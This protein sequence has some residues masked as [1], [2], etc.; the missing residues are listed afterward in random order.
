MSDQD[1]RTIVITGSGGGIGRALSIAAADVGMQVFGLDV[2]EDNGPETTR[3]VIERGGRATFF[4][5]DIQN[6]AALEAT[7]AAIE[8]QAGPVDILINNA[9]VGSHTAP[10][11]IT[12]EEWSKVI[13][14]TL[15][16]S[17]FAAQQA[18]R[19]M[20]RAGRAGAIVNIASIAGLSSLGRGSFAYGIAKAGVVSLTRE[21]A[22]E[23]ADY[24]IRVNGV[25]PSQVDTSSFRRLIDDPDVAGGN[26]FERALSG[27][28][29]GR[30][31]TT[32]DI[33]SVVMFLASEQAAFVSGVTVPVDG[34]SMAL[35]PGGSLRRLSSRKLP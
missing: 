18:G 22:V 10:E 8:D 35:H 17:V 14:V 6:V 1:N 23:W 4:P 11:D 13:G 9:A 26:I 28:P 2:E 15:G 12:F 3:I 21:L 24:G 34:G 16:G 5:C 25:A 19:S 31:A 33:V 30:L 32:E 7:F 20:I 27:I 29:L